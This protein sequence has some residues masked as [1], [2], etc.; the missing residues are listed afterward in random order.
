M[1]INS[2]ICFK[3]K[4]ANYL[5][6]DDTASRSA[7]PMKEDFQWLKE[8]GV[9]DIINFRTMTVSG[10]DFDEKTAVEE[11][12]MKYHTLPSYSKNP[13]EEN[14]IKFLNI[15]DDVK[16]KGGKVHIHCKAGADRTGMYSLIYKQKNKLGDL[17]SN[18][19][20]MINLG[21]DNKRYP[22]LISWIENLLKKLKI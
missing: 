14:V 9:T 13:K 15:V 11:N 18:K 16:K 4:P 6:I 1:R 2:I 20:E 12:G 17:V 10:L 7:Q 3:G 8:N 22:N 5:K 19:S 21:H